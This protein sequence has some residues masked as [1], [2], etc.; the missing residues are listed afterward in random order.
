MD[1]LL[2]NADV[3]MYA[4]KSGGKAR[5]AVFSPDMHLHALRRLDLERELRL[6]I[7]RDEFRLHYQPLVELESGQAKGFEAL[8]RWAHPERGLVPPGEFI[9]VAEETDLIRPIGR[10]V[11]AEAARQA[12]AWQVKYPG[13]E[14]SIVGEHHRQGPDERPVRARGRHRP[15]ATRPRPELADARG[16]RAGDHDRHRGHHQAPPG[17]ARPRGAHLGG[18]LRHRVLLAELPAQLPDRLAQDRQAVPGRRAR[19]RAGDAR[20]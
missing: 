17:A 7:E 8:I 6:A 18:R 12:R 1:E 11:L 13:E 9:P 15:V 14:I 16:D 10:W 19:E 3:A 4:A 2:R 20:W 5:S